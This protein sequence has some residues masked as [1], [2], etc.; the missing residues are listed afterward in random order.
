MSAWEHAARTIMLA[1]RERLRMIE[2]IIA[3]PIFD[4]RQCETDR[5]LCL[6]RYDKSLN[7]KTPKRCIF[8][9]MLR[10]KHTA[11]HYNK[12]AVIQCLRRDDSA[13]QI[14]ACI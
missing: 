9:N 8:V 7:I 1:V 11:I 13:A 10:F 2:D 3:P 5:R 6:W 14:K 4:W 12:D